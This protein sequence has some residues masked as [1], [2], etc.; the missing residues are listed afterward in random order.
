MIL[1]L[2]FSLV[3]FLLKIK[4]KGSLFLND[5][6]CIANNNINRSIVRK[7]NNL[8]KFIFFCYIIHFFSLDIISLLQGPLLYLSVFD[9]SWVLLLLGL[10]VISN[11]TNVKHNIMLPRSASRLKDYWPRAVGTQYSLEF[12]LNICVLLGGWQFE[13]V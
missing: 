10:T 1:V 7:E 6:K 11:V 5:A 8:I 12:C 4:D 13:M 3:N 9:V 2:F